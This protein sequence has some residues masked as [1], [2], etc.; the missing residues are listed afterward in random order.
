V[1]PVRTTEYALPA[2]SKPGA[3][4]RAATPEPEVHVPPTVEVVRPSTVPLAPGKT[5]PISRGRPKPAARRPTN[6]VS[7]AG[8]EKKR[9]ATLGGRAGV[10]AKTAASDSSGPHQP[11]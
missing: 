5:V 7:A 6:G 11:N 2:D 9:I 4:V 8:A 10:P 1:Q 3:P